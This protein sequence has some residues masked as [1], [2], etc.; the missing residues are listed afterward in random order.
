M[1]TVSG[2]GDKRRFL[3]FQRTALRAVEVPIVNRNKCFRAYIEIGGITKQMVCAGYDQGGRDACQGN[4]WRKIHHRFNLLNNIR[5]AGDSGGPLAC[6]S[7]QR[8]GAP[9]LYGIVSWGLDC[10]EPNYPGV[11]TRVQTFTDW[12][13]EN[14]GLNKSRQ[15]KWKW[16]YNYKKLN[17][18]NT[19]IT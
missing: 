6:G 9:V 17:D 5:I 14:T 3:F 1:C 2:W 16:I 18:S 10:A 19:E 11:Y 8:N 13:Y 4:I 7:V 15:F 12:I